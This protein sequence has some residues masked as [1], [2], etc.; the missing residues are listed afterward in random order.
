MWAR[1]LIVCAFLVAGCDNGEA[2]NPMPGEDLAGGG[3][4]GGDLAGDGGGGGGGGDMAAQTGCGACDQPPTPCHAPSGTCENGKCIYPLV[5]GLACDDHDPCTV[6]DLC[7]SGVCAGQARVCDAPPASQCLSGTQLI[8]YDQTGACNAG[9]CVYTQHTIT[10]G[11][12]GCVSNMCATDPCGSITCNQPPN[13][14]FKAAGTCSAGTCS[15]AYDDGATCN[16]GDPCTNNDQCNTGVCKGTPKSCV[17]PPADSCVDATTLKVYDPVGSCGGGSCS[18]TYR[19]V[20]CAAGCATNRCNATPWTALTSG[21]SVTLHDVWGASGTDVFAVGDLGTVL[22]YNGSLWKTMPVPVGTGHLR[23]VSG[24]ASD[25]VFAITAGNST[26]ANVIRWDG[27]SWTNR[28]SNVYCYDFCCV[29]AIGVD[30]AYVWNNAGQLIRITGGTATTVAST[31]L[32]TTLFHDCDV[33]VASASD[34][35]IGGAQVFHWNGSLL[36]PVKA[37]AG[38]AFTADGVIAF[39]PTQVVAFAYNNVGRWDGSQWG[40][41]PTGSTGSQESLG[42]TSFSRLFIAGGTGSGGTVFFWDGSGWSG[43]TLPASTP[44]LY[45]VWAATTG[46]VYAVGSNGTIIKA[47]H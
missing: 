36:A 14:C 47:I 9:A 37:A 34:V 1:A 6:G 32:G 11:A 41:I 33:R 10:C 18:Y 12:G 13:A 43:E 38:S 24:T 28:Q 15:Y 2:G 25:N 44:Y 31:T 39:G 45:G 5:E 7:S 35:Y 8:T 21:V 42:G 29:G 22:R 27:V 16:D 46:E 40:S 23:G 26:Y 3:G 20:T 19:F 30:D 17:S 4:G